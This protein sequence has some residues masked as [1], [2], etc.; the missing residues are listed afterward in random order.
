MHQDGFYPPFCDPPPTTFPPHG[1]AALQSP[2]LLSTWVVFLSDWERHT[3]RGFAFYP[4]LY[5]KDCFSLSPDTS[6]PLW[7]FLDLKGLMV[8]HR[9]WI[10]GNTPQLPLTA[11]SDKFREQTLSKAKVLPVVKCSRED[12]VFKI[13][14]I[15]LPWWRSGWESAC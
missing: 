2:P 1:A 8:W 10:F 13:K 15:G 3:R 7:F 12:F 11:A 9:T 5:F 4:L 6:N 14:W